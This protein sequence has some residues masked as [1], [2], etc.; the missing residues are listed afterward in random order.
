VDDPTVARALFAAAE[1]WLCDRGLRTV[2]GPVNLS[3]N[4]EC[5]MLI[6]SFDA[7]PSVLM[8]YNP[9]YY[10]PLVEACG[11]V[12]AKDLWAWELEGKRLPEEFLAKAEDLGA[13]SRYTI[14]T[15][16]MR[17]FDAEV[18]RVLSVYHEIWVDNWGYVPAT[19]DE[20]RFIVR[21]LKPILRPELMLLA[22]VDGEAVGAL[23]ALPDV[24]AAFK[25]A[26]GRLAHFGIPLGLFRFAREARRINAARLILLGVRERERDGGVVVQLGARAMRAREDLGI[27]RVEFSWILEDNHA[28]NGLA[29]YV[30]GRRSK[31]YRIYRRG[32]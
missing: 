1:G 17:D 29:R 3:T 32:S 24:N 7:V 15:L 31:T 10:P 23:I 22:E 19:E 9:A 27:G 30:G 18:S 8:P 5:G 13:G 25:A 26:N 4:H 14:R 11:F 20:F 6:D 28:A 2:L 16:S 21:A 12:K